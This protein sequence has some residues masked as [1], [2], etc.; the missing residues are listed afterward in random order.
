MLTKQL[1]SQP[2]GPLA[3]PGPQPWAQAT[4][5]HS[6]CHW[7]TVSLSRS[8]GA[9]SDLHPRAAPPSLCGLCPWLSH[10]QG[11]GSI[12]RS[13]AQDREVSVSVVSGKWKS[14]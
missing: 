2:Q 1:G 8:L 9:S 13:G 14:P 7:L 4:H 10:Q 5:V 3:P 6:A 11:A 12:A